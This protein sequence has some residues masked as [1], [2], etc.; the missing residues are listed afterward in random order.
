MC[1]NAFCQNSCHN[2]ASGKRNL[3]PNK[4]IF[5]LMLFCPILKTMIQIDG[6]QFTQFFGHQQLNFAC[7]G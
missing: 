5:L 6:D 2:L 3:V 7:L 1:I 4:K